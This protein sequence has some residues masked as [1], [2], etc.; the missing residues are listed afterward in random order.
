M[1]IVSPAN[2]LALR[3]PER[4]GVASSVVAPLLNGPRLIPNV[5]V[6]E[7]IVAVYRSDAE[8]A[9]AQPKEVANAAQTQAY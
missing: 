1:T 2:K 3:L 9:Q 8:T 5:S 4:V 6:A 7:V